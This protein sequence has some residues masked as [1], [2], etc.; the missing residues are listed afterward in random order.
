M[1][2]PEKFIL[3]E[4][5]S[6]GFRFHT[7][8]FNFPLFKQRFVTVPKKKQHYHFERHAVHSAGK[9]FNFCFVVCVMMLKK[10]CLG[11]K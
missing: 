7:K 11:P 6:R 10:G 1:K 3:V 5:N 2:C 4:R 9:L 8:N